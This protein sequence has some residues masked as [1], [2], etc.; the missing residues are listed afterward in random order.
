MRTFRQDLVA[1]FAEVTGVYR[2]HD[3]DG[4]VIGH[5]FHTKG[6]WHYAARG[7]ELDKRLIAEGHWLTAEKACP[8]GLYLGK[9]SYLSKGP[10]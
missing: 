9:A 4:F 2:V 1:F 6:G 5:V 8:R 7:M 10:F 3:K